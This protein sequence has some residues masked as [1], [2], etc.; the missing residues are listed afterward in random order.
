MPDKDKKQASKYSSLQQ[1]LGKAA[2]E[3]LTE[4]DIQKGLNSTDAN[5]VR[6]AKN[7]A[8]TVNKKVSKEEYAEMNGMRIQVAQIGMEAFAEGS[9]ISRLL[10]DTLPSLVEDTKGFLS[11]FNASEPGIVMKVNPREF[12]KEINKHSYLDIS[13]L[14]AFVPEGLDVPYQQYAIVLEAAAMH[15]SNVLSGIMN[16]Y[17][18]FLAQLISN[19]DAAL[20]TASFNREHDHL[21]KQR[22][23]F[24]MV[25]GS[26]FK[27]GSTKTEV[28]IRDVVERNAEWEEVIK[29]SSTIMDLVNNV[30]RKTLNKKITECSLYLDVILEKT[31][32]GE[33]KNLSPEGIKNLASGAYNVACELEFYSATY[34]R[35]LTYIN[36]IDMTAEHFQKIFKR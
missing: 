12:V 24:N 36:C 10:H 29:T 5:V 13:P 26:C 14:A 18:V 7:A 11:S 6:M 17:T 15:A 23:E 3:K 9:N 33:L 8:R 31:K 25:L 30:N 28:S 21:E 2:G 16:T 22:Q 19:P 4:K 1:F 35:A 27:N 32:R 20:S 34:Y